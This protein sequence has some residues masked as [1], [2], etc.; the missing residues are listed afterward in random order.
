MR[1]NGLFFLFV[2]TDFIV[3]KSIHVKKSKNTRHLNVL[4]RLLCH[5]WLHKGIHTDRLC[6]ARTKAVPYSSY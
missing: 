4:N 1:W 2:L 5:I 3:Y 6:F